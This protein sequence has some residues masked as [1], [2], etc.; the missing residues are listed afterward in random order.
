[1]RLAAKISLCLLVLSPLAIPARAAGITLSPEAA[2]A[3]DQIYNGDTDAA[4]AA[5][6]AV[7]QAQPDSPVGYLLE[8]EAQWWKMYCVACEIRW[9]MLD[10]YKRGKKPEDESYFALA[11]KA[12]NWRARK[13]PSQTL[14]KCTSTSRSVS[15]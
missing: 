2:T 1:M 8:D 6:H 14:P 11:D 9:G 4:I 7:E 13:S 15:P 12:S 5:A 3:L 10:A